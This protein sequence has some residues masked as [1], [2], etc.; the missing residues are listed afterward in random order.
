MSIYQVLEAYQCVEKGCLELADFE[1]LLKI[2]DQSFTKE[3]VET[4]FGLVCRKGTS[5]ITCD[6]FVRFFLQ[7]TGTSGNKP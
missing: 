3:E 4:A 1:R 2:L 5:N 7:A 6:E